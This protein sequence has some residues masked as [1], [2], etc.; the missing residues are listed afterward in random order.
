[1]KIQT[2]PNIN[3]FSRIFFEYFDFVKIAL[4]R[5]DLADFTDLNNRVNIHCHKQ[6]IAW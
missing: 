5:T 6:I 1:M 3:V 2:N 4:F